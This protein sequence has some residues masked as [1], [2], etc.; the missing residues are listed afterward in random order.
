MTRLSRLPAALA[1]P[2]LAALLATATSAATMVPIVGGAPMYP[3]RSIVENA[4]ASADH[5]TLVAA[6]TAAGLVET[7]SGPGPFTVF[8]PTDDAFP[9]ALT[10]VLDVLHQPENLKLLQAVLTYH[11]VPGRL[12]P[13]QL[14]GTH[15]TLEGA[16]LSVMGSGSQF[17]V[18]GTAKVVCGNVPTA[19]AT[20]YLIDGVL[21]P[22]S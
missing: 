7:L 1:A 19:N 11:V 2:V 13:D 4:A 6:V 3:N 14:A 9:A 8:A 21:L 22:K 17:T 5:Q 16:T 15:K 18:N 10:P 20:V 12:S